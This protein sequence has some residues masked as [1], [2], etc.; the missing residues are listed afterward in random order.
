MLLEARS[1]T[2]VGMVASQVR[3]WHEAVILFMVSLFVFLIIFGCMRRDPGAQHLPSQN[4]LSNCSCF[5]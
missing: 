5:Q 2:E 4:V 1:D 3:S